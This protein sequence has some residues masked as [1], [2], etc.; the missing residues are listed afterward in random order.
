MLNIILRMLMIRIRYLTMLMLLLGGSIGLWAQD[1]FNPASPAEPGPPGSEDGSVPMLTLLADPADGGTVRGMGWYDVASKVTVRAS[2]KT[3]FVFTCWTNQQGDTISTESQFK[4]TKLEGN[5]TLTA[6]FRFSPGSPAE[7]VE[8]AQFVYHQLTLKADVGGSVSGG[9]KYLPGTRIY[10]SASVNTGFVFDGW[11]DSAGEL[12]SSSAKFYYTT[13]AAAVTLTARFAFDPSAP[14]EPV[15]PS[16]DTT[17]THTLTITAGEGGTANTGVFTIKEGATATL[18]ATANANYEFTGWYVADTLYSTVRS[19]KYTMQQADIAF[20]AHFAF[21]PSAPGEPTEAKAKRFTFML[22]NRV[23]KA[24]DTIKFPV[25]LTSTDSI[26]DMLFQLTFPKD[27]LPEVSTAEISAKAEGY[28]V[29]LTEITDPV[30]LAL[31]SVDSTG[32]VYSLSFTGGKMA[33]GNTILLNFLMHVDKDIDTGKGYPVR[34]NQ[35]SMTLANG[36]QV[37]AATRNGRISVYKSGDVNGDNEVNEVDA[38]QILDV[39]AGIVKKNELI[40]P[41]VIDVPGGNDDALEVNAQI[42]LDYSVAKDKPW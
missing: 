4:Y 20:T 8:I 41:E 6:H 40:V 5:E 29:S 24:G 21:N 15:T 17:P 22:Y 30:I 39:S 37:S 12:V 25:Y 2:N 26:F 14:G 36:N 31:A 11:Y 32:T 1:D 28:T 18:T 19:F 16:F 3:D 35:V 9:G 33:A 42:V 38:Q 10:L 13:T 23:C 27:I 34:I 7:P